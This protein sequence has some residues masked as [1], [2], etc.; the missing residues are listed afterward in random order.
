[1]ASTTISGRGTVDNSSGAGL[2]VTV[3]STFSAAANF[4]N[5]VT[6]SYSPTTSAQSLTASGSVTY[7]GLYTLSNATEAGYFLP[8]PANAP[9]G[10]FTFRTLGAAGKAHFLTGTNGDNLG[11]FITQGYIGAAGSNQRGS[12]LTLDSTIGSS[13]TLISDGLNFC[14]MANSGTLT[15]ATP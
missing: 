9:G 5:A 4:T 10:V 1:M 13:V 8:N 7:P 11:R 15:F 2:T 6:M 14:V 12:K 3:D